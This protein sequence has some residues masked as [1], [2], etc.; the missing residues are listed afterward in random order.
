MEL[1][2]VAQQRNFSRYT[3]VFNLLSVG[4]IIII[5]RF[6]IYP[7]LSFCQCFEIRLEMIHFSFIIHSELST[8]I[9]SSLSSSQFT[10]L[11]ICILRNQQCR[12]IK[13]CGV[14]CSI[15]ILN[16][17]VHNNILIPLIL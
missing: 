14:S 11:N 9:L 17:F 1:L 7:F 2:K 8:F 5:L 4:F 6:T 10:Y 3:K 16:S 15:R 12:F 13:K